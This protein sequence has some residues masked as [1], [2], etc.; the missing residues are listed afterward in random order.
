[1]AATATNFD[2]IQKFQSPSDR[3]LP[4][5]YFGQWNLFKRSFL[6]WAMDDQSKNARFV[7]VGCMY[8]SSKNLSSSAS[9]K[10]S[11]DSKLNSKW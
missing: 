5:D 3:E 10:L 4:G 6:A 1:M 11:E 9:T 2:E 8:V 7:F